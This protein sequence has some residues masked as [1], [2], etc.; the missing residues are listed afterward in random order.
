M[1]P[2]GFDIKPRHNCL[3]EG[4]RAEDGP[5]ECACVCG[6]EGVTEVMRVLTSTSVTRNEIQCH[7]F[8]IYGRNE[9][10]DVYFRNPQ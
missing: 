6:G 7:R 9:S 10:F 5:Q 1:V 8:R 4:Q 2:A 3:R